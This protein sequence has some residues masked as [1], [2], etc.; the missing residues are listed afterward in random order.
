MKRL[1][2]PGGEPPPAV[3]TDGVA[4]TPLAEEVADRYLAEYADDLDRYGP[5]VRAWAVHD[6]QW[7]LWWAANEQIDLGAQ[8][9]WLA[10]VLAARDFPLERLARNLE[11]AADVAAGPLPAA[12]PRL[13]AAARLVAP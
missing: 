10:R 5:H 8:V 13:R 1:D 11:L 7:Q 3:S 6:T 2:P 9:S 4:L 12:A